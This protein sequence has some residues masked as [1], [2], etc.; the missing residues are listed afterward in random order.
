MSQSHVMVA[1][2][3]LV[4]VLFVCGAEAAPFANRT[5]LK[6]AV[7]ACLA[8]DPTGMACCGSA[9]DSSCGDPSTA[10]CG[11]A[12]CMEMPFWDTSF[13]TDMESMFSYASAFNA[14]ISGWDTSSVTNMHYMFS[15]ASA[16]N[17]DIS[18]WDTRFVTQMSNMFEGSSMFNADISG[19]DTS[20]VTR[21]YA[22]FASTSAF[23]ADISG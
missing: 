22:M 15:Y 8:Y 21:M 2:V 5:A 7:D 6:G 11:V 4:V 13:V 14:D 12:G 9:Y 1:R 20:F 23:N 10:R 19:W 17:A 18:G 16:F 3:L